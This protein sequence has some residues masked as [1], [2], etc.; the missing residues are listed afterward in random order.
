MDKR[1]TFA[2]SDGLGRHFAEAIDITPR[3]G[4]LVKIA[5]AM[6][7]EVAAF[8]K[9]L[10]P[11]PA[12]QYVLMTP[13]GSYEIWGQNVN[14]D[15]FPECILRH[16]WTRDDP[17]QTIKALL[18]KYP[19][20]GG[21]FPPGNYSEFGYK[22]F[23]DAR[24]YLHHA[25]KQPERAYGDVV[26]SAWNP[27][28]HRVEIIVRHDREKAKQVGAEE[29][30]QDIDEGRPRQL[31]MGCKTPFDYCSVCGK[32]SRSTD[33]YCD[34]LKFRMGS[35]LRDGRAVCAINPFPRFFDLS[36]VFVPAAKESGVLMK[37]AQVAGSYK[38]AST[39]TATIEKQVTPN[40]SSP[41]SRGIS[42]VCA[43]EPS[44]PMKA[45]MDRVE[46][47][48]ILLTTLAA[49]GIVAK[50]EEFQ[51]ALLRRMG[52][53]GLA[54]QLMDSRQVFSQEPSMQAAGFGDD[55][56]SPQ[57]ARVLSALL[58]ERSAFYPHLPARIIRVSVTRAV[59]GPGMEAA[60]D[61]PEIRKVASAYASYR[62]ALRGL[63]GIVELALA[64]D[65]DYYRDNFFQDLV[66]DALTKTSS[67]HGARVGTAVVPLYV[68]SAY[69]GEVSSVPDSWSF[70]TSPLSSIRSLLGP[71]F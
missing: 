4:G 66:S 64:R 16:D 34:D 57:L 7:P 14:G 30:I 65:P 44:L 11:D 1:V 46:D 3:G 61:S 38:S 42:A 29:V 35:V 18:E 47:P 60:P 22:T 37:V 19:P 13:M 8:V 51:Y 70:P 63:P 56:Y 62:G 31:S 58:P 17:V 39:K 28:M 26:L 40:T 33:D 55:G 9:T 36:D 71:T 59:P 67:M 50:P 27:T 45:L 5:G 10:R 12:Y 25:N 43:A 41:A 69:R 24:R 53:K 20:A 49:L 21:E 2:T 32:I 48:T 54:D 23:L 6:Q 68:Y 52:K 15:A